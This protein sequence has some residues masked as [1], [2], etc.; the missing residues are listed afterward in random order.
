MKRVLWIVPATLILFTTACT[1]ALVAPTALMI[2]GSALEDPS[3]AKLA[4][5]APASQ[6]QSGSTA[7]HMSGSKDGNQHIS[8]RPLNGHISGGSYQ[9]MSGGGYY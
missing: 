9:H 5:N 8:G 3:S 1:A 7:I 2:M 4:K 6:D